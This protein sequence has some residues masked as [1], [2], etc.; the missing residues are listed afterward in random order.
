MRKVMIVFTVVF[1]LTAVFVATPRIVTAMQLRR[2]LAAVRAATTRY[3][4]VNVAIADGYMPTDTCL[5]RPGSGMGY[6]YF[7]PKLGTD[8]AN[9]PLKPELMIYA[10]NGNGRKLV[11]VEYFQPDV[12]QPRPSIFGQPFNGPMPGHE[13]GMP[14]HYDLHAWI[15]QANPDGTFAQWNPNISC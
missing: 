15:W 3:R 7:N 4:D 11:A 8:V 10:P 2:D 5:D 9:D 12:G 1:V 6:H 14:A 13:P